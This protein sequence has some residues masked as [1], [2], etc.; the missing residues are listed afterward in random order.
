MTTS[1]ATTSQKYGTDFSFIA[2][3][4]KCCHIQPVVPALHLHKC[5]NSCHQNKQQRESECSIS[6]HKKSIQFNL[7]IIN[8][9][10]QPECCNPTIKKI[11]LPVGEGIQDIPTYKGIKIISY[12]QNSKPNVLWKGGQ[13][14]Q[15]VLF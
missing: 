10:T 13:N 3:L 6:V 4:S 2:D 7:L 9:N 8:S 15:I 12:Q 14:Q 11:N 5:K 1:C